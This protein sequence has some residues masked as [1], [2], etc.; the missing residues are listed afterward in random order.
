MNSSQ[1]Q[2]EIRFL[3]SGHRKPFIP[4]NF[5]TLLSTSFCKHFQRLCKLFSNA[6]TFKKHYTGNWH[7]YVTQMHCHKN[8]HQTNTRTRYTHAGYR[9]TN[10]RTPFTHTNTV[11]ART[12]THTNRSHTRTHATCVTCVWRGMKDVRGCR[13]LVRCVCVCVWVACVSVLHEK[14]DFW[15]R[16]CSARPKPMATHKHIHTQTHT[17]THTHW[18]THTLTR[19]LTHWR[20]DTLTHWHTDTFGH[21]RWHADA[22]IH[23]HIDTL[24]YWH[25]GTDTLTQWHTHLHRHTDTVEHAL[26]H[27]HWIRIGSLYS[28]CC[29]ICRVHVVRMF[30]TRFW[31]RVL[32]SGR[33]NWPR[34]LRNVVDKR[35]ELTK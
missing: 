32:I 31:G 15:I 29:C 7:T 30:F 4:H 23:W 20:T 22:L 35:S 34:L 2:H 27:W 19:R 9:H 17:H 1:E 6:C 13:V 18:H 12:H 33:T 16:S 26:T 14:R 3:N 28:S 25:T 11:H 21:W 5:I 8:A 24:T 10:T